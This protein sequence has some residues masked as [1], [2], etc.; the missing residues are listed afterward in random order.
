VDTVKIVLLGAPASGKGTQSALL[1]D[2]FEIPA[3]S[4]GVV[5]RREIEKRSELGILAKELLR[6]GKLLTDEAT[7][8]IVETWIDNEIV[9]ADGFLFDG[10][11]R[12]VAQ[13]RAFQEILK[14]RGLS[15]DAVIY[16]TATRETIEERVLGRLQCE[17]CGNVYRASQSV[18]AGSSC[19]ACGKGE[20]SRRSDDKPAMLA[21]RMDEYEEKTAPLVPFYQEHAPGLLKTIDGNQSA[22]RVFEAICKALANSKATI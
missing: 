9:A 17:R 3:V 4:T 18:S 1:S 12:T 22:D 2:H 6:Q 16:L 20:L 10:F 19:G 13:G 5:I 11:P 21:K 8:K 7:L 15:L 14:R